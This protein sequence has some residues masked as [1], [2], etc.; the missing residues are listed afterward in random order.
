MAERMVLAMEASEHIPM[1]AVGAAHWFIGENSLANLL[2]QSGYSLEKVLEP[3]EASLF[4]DAECEFVPVVETTDEPISTT[5]APVTEPTDAPVPEPTSA[6]VPE[7]TGEPV[8]ATAATS[9]P[10]PESTS[11]STAESTNEPSNAS[12]VRV[13]PKLHAI[14]LMSL[15]SVIVSFVAF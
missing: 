14:A 15:C 10:T 4:P 11:S 7:P 1:F 6:P 12:T 13:D 9:S 2:Q 3:Y 5:N 8:T